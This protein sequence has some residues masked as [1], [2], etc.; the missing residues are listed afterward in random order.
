MG[1][2]GFLDSDFE[3]KKLQIYYKQPFIIGPIGV[4][5][6]TMELGKT[7]GS[8]PLGLMSIIPGNQT[9]FTIRNTFNLLNFYEFEAD[10]YATLQL[11]HNFGGRI[12]A[13]IPYLRKFNLR[14]TIGI[15][16]AYGSITD[17]SRALNASGINYKAPENV[18]WEYNAGIGN[19]YKVF[20]IEFS[21][22]GSYITPQ[23]NNFGIKGSFGIFF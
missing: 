22:R 11:E 14:E 16:G 9:Y 21:W 10:Q 7:F 5:N 2:K 18:Y 17:G 3:Y 1:I 20:R 6:S 4:L 15:R 8:V 23:S 13:R 12:F 19:I